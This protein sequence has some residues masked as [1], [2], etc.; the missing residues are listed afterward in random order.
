MREHAPGSLPV[1]N[2]EKLVHDNV[3]AGGAGGGGG[4]PG[5]PGRL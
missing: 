2:G 1:C 5:G 4:P 3:Q